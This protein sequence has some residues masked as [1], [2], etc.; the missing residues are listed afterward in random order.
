[1]TSESSGAHHASSRRWRRVI[2]PAVVV[3]AALAVAPAAQA[4]TAEPRVLVFHGTAEGR[5]ASIPAGVEAIH[6]L[7]ARNGFEVVDT[8]DPGV[9]TPNTLSG[10]H[11][12]VFLSANGD[13][14]SAE[15][16]AAFQEYIRAGGG[17]LGIHDAAHVE[18]GSAWFTGL[19]GTR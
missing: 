18:R 4:Q 13:I 1:M 10:Y 6:T 17:F 9:F 19:I 11:S 5:H 12:V 16:E 8:Q 3:V 2:A 7:G 15:Q 14:L